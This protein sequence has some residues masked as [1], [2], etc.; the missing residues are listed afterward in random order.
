MNNLFIYTDYFFIAIYVLYVH[1]KSRFTIMTYLIST[2]HFQSI[3]P[4]EVLL[5]VKYNLCNCIIVQDGEIT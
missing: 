1:T 5:V 4:S 2:F 3:T